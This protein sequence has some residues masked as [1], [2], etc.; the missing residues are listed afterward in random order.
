MSDFTQRL[1]S[2][3]PHHQ[4]RSF[5]RGRWHRQ[6]DKNH[7]PSAKI[8]VG[9][10]YFT[11]AHNCDT[12]LIINYLSRT[13]SI[14]SLLCKIVREIDCKQQ[15]I[16]VLKKCQKNRP[17]GMIQ[18]AF[19]FEK[20]SFYHQGRCCGFYRRGVHDNECVSQHKTWWCRD[21]KC[22]SAATS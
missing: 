4:R 3:T 19:K 13:R 17:F 5:Q 10:W 15:C 16:N 21:R 1:E 8:P 7:S 18:F 20:K 6:K 14:A 2:S 9:T 11:S 22:G 12:I